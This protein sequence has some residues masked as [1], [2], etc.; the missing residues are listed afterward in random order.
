MLNFKSPTGARQKGSSTSQTSEDPAQS[1]TA[2]LAEPPPQTHL[3]CPA[4]SSLVPLLVF[5]EQ[6]G[7]GYPTKRRVRESPGLTQLPAPEHTR[8]P[9]PTML[10][11]FV[12]FR[13]PASPLLLRS[14]FH[15]QDQGGKSGRKNKN[16]QQ[17]VGNQEVR[18]QICLC[19]Y[20]HTCYWNSVKSD[21]V[22]LVY[23][24]QHTAVTKDTET[25]HRLTQIL[26][27]F[28]QN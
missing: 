15:L 27:R 24:P 6:P 19:F 12:L 4:L 16:Q 26:K 9:L 11:L 28:A 13:S 14:H 7:K 22:Q 23:C 21:Q 20:C 18:R 2:A 25:G 1:L 5:R 8:L 10:S 17:T 3:P